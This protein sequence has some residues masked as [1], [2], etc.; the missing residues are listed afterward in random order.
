MDMKRRV[1]ELERRA[2]LTGNI[3]VHFFALRHGDETKPYFVEYKGQTWTQLTDESLDQF[4]ERV[5]GL[6]R[7]IPAPSGKIFLCAKR[8]HLSREQSKARW[9]EDV[10]GPDW[11]SIVGDP[12]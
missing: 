5:K 9:M 2:G 11:R 8:P 6:V 12:A 1:S 4:E 7:L 3:P 10:H